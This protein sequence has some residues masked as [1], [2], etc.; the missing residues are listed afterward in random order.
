LEYV[1]PEEPWPIAWKIF[2]NF[3]P[4]STKKSSAAAT[5]G[6]KR[7]SLSTTRPYE[8]ARSAPNQ[9]EL[10]GLVGLRGAALPMTASLTTGPLRREEGWKREK[11]IRRSS[12]S[13]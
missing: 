7:S 1:P 5:L 9:R 13:R 12:T 2:K 8:P 10:L 11:V 4:A 3:A 6:I